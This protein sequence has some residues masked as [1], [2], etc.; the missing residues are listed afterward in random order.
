MVGGLV[1][2]ALGL[3]VLPFAREIPLLVVAMSL[4]ALGMG[5]MQPSLNSLI[6]RRAA[7][8]R[9]GEVMGV[10]QSVGALSRV[11]GPIIAGALFSGLGANSPF[12]WGA[13]LVAIALAAGWR[14][15]SQSSPA[16]SGIAPRPQR[17]G[18]A[19]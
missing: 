17:P 1:L 12:L 9:Q 6:S 14:L 7:P 15:L 5:A 4:L 10:A 16:E 3:L 18:P 19:E 13:L 11:L 8:E 2:I